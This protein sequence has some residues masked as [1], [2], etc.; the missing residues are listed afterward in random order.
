MTN[1]VVDREGEYRRKMNI[2]RSIVTSPKVGQSPETKRL[3][4]LKKEISR[5][6]NKS[7]LVLGK[8]FE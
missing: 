6:I 2:K 7:K 3:K 5:S 4:E 8:D 1:Y